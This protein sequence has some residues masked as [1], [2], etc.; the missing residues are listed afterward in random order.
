MNLPKNLKPTI[1]LSR[2]NYVHDWDKDGLECDGNVPKLQI[3][4][5]CHWNK[6]IIR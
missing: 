3:V 4:A 5:I 1:G 6:V 2:P